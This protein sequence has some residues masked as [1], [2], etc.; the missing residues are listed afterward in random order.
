MP[1]QKTILVIGV[2]GQQGGAIARSLLRQQQK[3]RGLVRSTEKASAKV[4]ALQK[5][6]VEVVAGD[7]TDPASLARA[8]SGVDG[9]YAMTT[10]FEAG[11]E[12]E[13]QQGKTLADVVNSAHIPH[14]VF[15]SVGS[16]HRNTGIPH[17]ES[18]WKIEQYIQQLGLPTTILRPAFFIENFAT[19]FLEGIV[20]GVLTLPLRPTTKLQ[21]VAVKD[22]GEFG[23][24][25]FLRTAEFLRQAIDFAGDELTMPEVTAHLSRTMGRPI[26]FQQMPD[27]QAEAAMGR[28]MALMFRWF[29]EVGY[30]ADMPALRKRFG[31]P[32]TSFTEV[33][34]TADWA[35]G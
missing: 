3:V 11:E 30:S 9:V 13:V 24:A 2:T 35:K 21:M 33:L 22:I 25:A 17:F 18:K 14:L 6:G 27:D 5:L 26:Q 31:I 20:K 4:E 28:D 7:L 23:A 15:S 8:V 34:A 32:L 10:P 19:F 12:A 29:N 16:A 1:Q